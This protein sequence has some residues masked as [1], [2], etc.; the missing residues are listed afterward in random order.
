[1]MFSGIEFKSRKEAEAYFRELAIAAFRTAVKLFE[2]HG[3][4]EASVY[5]DQKAEV[6]V[7]QYGF[8]WEQIE[9]M[10]G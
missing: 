6:L 4:M 1:M 10:G 8:T 9:E 3:T 2:N 7:K 5:L